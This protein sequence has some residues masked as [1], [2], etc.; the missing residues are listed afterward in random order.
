IRRV[1]GFRPAWRVTEMVCEL[2]T[3]RALDNRFLEATHGGVE[4][5]GRDRTLAEKVV[6]D[7]ARNRCEGAVRRK[8]FPS[9]AHRLSSCYAP[10]T[11]LRTPSTTST[12]PINSRNRHR[13][14]RGSLL[15]DLGA[16]ILPSSRNTF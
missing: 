2:A 16:I 11:K 13:L 12:S 14:R 9:A 1:V 7:L 5:L 6:Q 4:L 10:H 8:A 15:K 3:E